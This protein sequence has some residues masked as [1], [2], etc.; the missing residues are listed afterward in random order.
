MKECIHES[1]FVFRGC[2]FFLPGK[3]KSLESF[4]SKTVKTSVRVIQQRMVYRYRRTFETF[5]MTKKKTKREKERF[6][7]EIKL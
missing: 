4:K 7:D 6:D 2:C 1:V 5:S 3:S